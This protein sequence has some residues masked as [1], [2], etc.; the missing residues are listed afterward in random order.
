MKTKGVRVLLWCVG[1]LEDVSDEV[2]KARTK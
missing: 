2:Q 1:L